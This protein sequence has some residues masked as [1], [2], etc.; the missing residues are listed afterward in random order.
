M[1]ACCYIG[2]GMSTITATASLAGSLSVVLYNKFTC[3]AKFLLANTVSDAAISGLSFINLAS[4]W[5]CS[6]G[7]YIAK[8]VVGDRATA[9]AVFAT[10]DIGS[11]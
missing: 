2:A 11:F 3:P 4:N 8:S 9:S 6:D 1:G 7:S 5:W 10:A